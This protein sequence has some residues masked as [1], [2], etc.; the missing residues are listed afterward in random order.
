MKEL[1]SSQSEAVILV[2]GAPSCVA[3]APV[4][5]VDEGK[6]ADDL[7]IFSENAAV[8]DVVGAEKYVDVV[9]GSTPVRANAGIEYE[10]FTFRKA[11]GHAFVQDSGGVVD[12][13]G[14]PIYEFVSLFFN[15]MS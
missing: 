12:T 15:M 3:R 7:P 5:S 6:D 4:A 2:A 13:S 10:G 1:S 9:G 8:V 11:V 14:L